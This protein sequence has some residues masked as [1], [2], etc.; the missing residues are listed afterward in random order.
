ME[1]Q[2]I[3]VIIAPSGEVEIRVRG[4]EGATCLDI[5]STLEDALGGKIIHREMTPEAV[6][7]PQVAHKRKPR[8]RKG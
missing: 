8:I 7:P 2:E 1:I 6:P 4:I 5:T 3:E